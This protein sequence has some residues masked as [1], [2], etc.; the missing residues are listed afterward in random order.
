MVISV[1]VAYDQI[2]EDSAFQRC[3]WLL[4]SLILSRRRVLNIL[5]DWKNRF[6]QK[7]DLLKKP[8]PIK[9][10]DSLSSMLEFKNSDWLLQVMRLFPTTIED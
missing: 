8:G 5:L 2:L 4:S 7:Y 6:Y 3:M 10:S 1:L 9:I